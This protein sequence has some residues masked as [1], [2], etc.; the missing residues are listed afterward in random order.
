M[1]DAA[2]TRQRLVAILAADAAGYSRL[3][4]RDE[5]ATIASLDAARHIFRTSI[6]SHRGRVIDM[7]G[8]SVLAVFD[9][10]TSAVSAALE[11]QEALEASTA[12]VPADRRMRFRIGVHMGDI[13]EKADGSV[14]GDGV[15]IAA[16]LEG[17]ALPGGITVSDAVWGSVRNRVAGTF[18]DLGEQQVKNIADPVRVFRVVPKE[19][20]ANDDASTP[21]QLLASARLLRRRWRWWWWGAPIGIVLIGAAAMLAASSH[22]STTI[23]GPP[24]LSIAVLPFKPSDA[25]GS[26]ARD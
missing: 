11:V 16:R 25:A 23:A 3:M 13:T 1:S 2:E 24:L 18:E 10:A 22:R 7:A 14:Y 4:A 6:G 15:N 20:G 21:G 9:T 17:L 5:R 8:D 19:A 26:G 12:G